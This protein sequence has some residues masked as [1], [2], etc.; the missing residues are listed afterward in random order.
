MRYNV[1]AI[2]NGKETDFSNSIFLGPSVNVEEQMTPK[3]DCFAYISNGQI[4]IMGV[5]D[6]CDAS[7]QVIDMMGRV[8]VSV[9]G[10]TRCVPTNGMTPG[11]YVLRLINGNDVKTQKIIVR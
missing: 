4:I 7:L 2:W 5:T 6:A 8:I 3:N 10:R 11:V 1:T 9:G